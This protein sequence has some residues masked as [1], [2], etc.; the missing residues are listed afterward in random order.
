MKRC[1]NKAPQRGFF[2]S[3]GYTRNELYRPVIDSANSG[4]QII[5]N[6]IHLNLSLSGRSGIVGGKY[7]M[8]VAAYYGD[9]PRF[10]LLHLKDEHKRLIMDVVAKTGL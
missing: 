2:H 3:M 4:N 8:E 10:S 1:F 6:H 5:P 7:A 9:T